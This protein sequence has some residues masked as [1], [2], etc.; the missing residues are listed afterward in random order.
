MGLTNITRKR[1]FFNLK[2]SC[3][4][5]DGFRFYDTI[6]ITTCFFPK[7]IALALSANHRSMLYQYLEF[8]LS[9][10]MNC[11]SP[12]RDGILTRVPIGKKLAAIMPS[13]TNVFDAVINGVESV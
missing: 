4:S 11:L 1:V 5:Q 7:W 6:S 8:I 9:S 13:L 3:D 12:Y 2:P 10:T